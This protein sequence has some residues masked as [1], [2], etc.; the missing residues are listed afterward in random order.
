MRREEPRALLSVYAP[1][2]RRPKRCLLTRFKHSI[3]RFHGVV[4]EFINLE[5][6]I[7]ELLKKNII[8]VFLIYELV[9]F[10]Q[11]LVFSGG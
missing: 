7:T 5:E 10:I 1:P 11:K 3:R 2:K 6:P 9:H 8:L 4:D